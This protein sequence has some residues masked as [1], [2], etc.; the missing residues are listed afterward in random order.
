MPSL[1]GWGSLDLSLREPHDLPEGLGDSCALHEWLGSPISSLRELLMLPEG[2]GVSA[3]LPVAERSHEAIPTSL[4]PRLRGTLHPASPPWG[5]GR[6]GQTVPWRVSR[7]PRAGTPG[8][9]GAPPDAHVCFQRWR[10][11]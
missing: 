4:T 9:G 6:G 8:D 2:L 10:L 3:A 5:H 7:W 11:K 1:G